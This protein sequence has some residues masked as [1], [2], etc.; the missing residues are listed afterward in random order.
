VAGLPPISALS[1]HSPTR[2]VAVGTRTGHV[3]LL[4]YP[5]LPPQPPAPSATSDADGGAGAGAGGAGVAL[6]EIGADGVC[7]PIVAATGGTK[8]PAD[9]GDAQREVLSF[10]TYV[11]MPSDRSGS[12]I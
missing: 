2:T 6:V 8:R 7:V 9:R 12:V 4:A 5:T 10:D 11:C 3:R 1:A